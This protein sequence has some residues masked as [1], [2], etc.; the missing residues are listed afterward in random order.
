[1]TIE[2]KHF[3]ATLTLF[4]LRESSFYGGQV[5]AEPLSGVEWMRGTVYNESEILGGYAD[6][7]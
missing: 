5:S 7:I 2:S 3:F 4:L 1:M 6:E